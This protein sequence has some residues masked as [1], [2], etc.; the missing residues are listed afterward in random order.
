MLHQIQSMSPKY[1]YSCKL[2]DNVYDNRDDNLLSFFA[3]IILWK[4]MYLLCSS[5][6][7]FI[8]NLL[9]LLQWNAD[10]LKIVISLLIKIKLTDK[11]NCIGKKSSGIC[12]GK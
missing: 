11:N 9:Y 6:Y 1:R 10:N 7:N 4:C 5:L 8:V 2:F 12:T 3:L